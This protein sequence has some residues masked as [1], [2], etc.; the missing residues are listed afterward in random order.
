MLFPSRI[1]K[2]HFKPPLHVT[3][4]NQADLASETWERKVNSMRT[5]APGKHG[6][7]GVAFICC[8]GGGCVSAKGQGAAAVDFLR[9]QFVA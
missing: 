5:Q 3:S 9:E 8:S 4:S 7:G 2:I 1:Q 6:P